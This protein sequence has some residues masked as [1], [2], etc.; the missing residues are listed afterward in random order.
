[1]VL[2][3][4]PGSYVVVRTSGWVAETIR[5][6]TGGWSNHAFIV[7]HDGKII[8]AQPGGVVISS[9][10]KYK[11]C[12]MAVNSPDDYN[13]STD[14]EKVVNAALSF[15]G[16]P[17]NDIDILELGLESVGLGMWALRKIA[18]DDGAVICSQMVAAAGHLS[19]INWTCG[20]K[21]FA[22][23]RPVDLEE[24]PGVKPF[25]L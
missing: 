18:N 24:R 8:E 14:P 12:R 13:R 2:T 4:E 17:Y 15:I 23:V 6:L 9:L 1:M 20:K 25:T 16:R 21:S 5:I 11:G 7:G 22:E 19:G 3:P 10:E